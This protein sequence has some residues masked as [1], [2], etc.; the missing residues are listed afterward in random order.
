MNQWSDDSRNQG[1]SNEAVNERMDKWWQMNELTDVWMDGSMT[2]LLLCWD[3]SSLSELFAEVPLLSATSSLSSL[4]SGLLLLWSAYAWSCFPATCFVASS[5]QCFSSCS[6]TMHLA[7]SRCN[8]ATHKG[9]ESRTIFRK[10]VTMRLATSN[11]NPTCQEPRSKSH[12]LRR[13][14]VPMHFVTAG[15][16]PD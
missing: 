4:L 16:K 11:W 9:S 5:T 13:A 10:A 7:T 12:A 8:S 14:A 6:V 2:E 3:T 1:W 15:C